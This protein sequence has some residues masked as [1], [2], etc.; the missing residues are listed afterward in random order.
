M[1]LS[2]NLPASLLDYFALASRNN[3]VGS[4]ADSGQP[5]GLGRLVKPLPSPLPASNLAAGRVRL[6]PCHDPSL[7]A[8]YCRS[9][10]DRRAIGAQ[11]DRGRSK[12][13]T[14][15]SSNYVASSGGTVKQVC[16]LHA[17]SPIQP[18]LG[19][20]RGLPNAIR[21]Y[22]RL[23]ICATEECSPFRSLLSRTREHRLAS[24]GSQRAAEIGQSIKSLLLL[25]REAWP[26]QLW[27]EPGWWSRAAGTYCAVGAMGYRN[28]P[29]P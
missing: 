9:A 3:V 17:V 18:G 28:A 1:C 10:D 19:N 27:T 20:S 29:A 14:P 16:S 11:A 22:S 21:R 23:K 25:R 6:Q 8:V 26:P 15:S 2:A 7:G 13:P 24:L 5:T 4:G 12:L